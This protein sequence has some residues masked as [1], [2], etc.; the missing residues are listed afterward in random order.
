M[1]IAVFVDRSLFE[2]KHSGQSTGMFKMDQLK[3]L[4]FGNLSS[5]TF[6]IKSQPDNAQNKQSPS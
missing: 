5:E 1:S 4:S 3:R 6:A 2:K